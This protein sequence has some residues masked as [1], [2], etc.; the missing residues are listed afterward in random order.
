MF[1]GRLLLAVGWLA[2]CA[3]SITFGQAAKDS[4]RAASG[5]SITVSDTHT[6]DVVSIRP[7]KSGGFNYWRFTP[8][9]WLTTNEDI[10]TIIVYAY[11]LQDPNL[12]VMTHEKAESGGQIETIPGGPKWINRGDS[13]DIQARMSDFDVEEFK[14]LNPAQKTERRREMMR[15][16]LA[17]RF[18]LKVHHETRLVPCFALVTAKDGPKNMKKVPD[19]KEM[20]W[21]WSGRN[22]LKAKATSTAQLSEIILSPRVECPVSD[23]TQLIGKYDFSLEW[24][25][26]PILTSG[27]DAGGA[28]LPDS[29]GPSIFTAVQKQLGLKLQPTKTAIDSIIIDHIERPSEN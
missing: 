15:A 17:D 4:Q 6:F 16:M 25:P 21:E 3:P 5:N 10:Q 24:V 2:A 22:S 9:G 13:Y 11:D 28:S 20:T 12:R 26:D 19:D 14:K 23:D 29:S 27:A 18:K 1:I 7:N 8:E